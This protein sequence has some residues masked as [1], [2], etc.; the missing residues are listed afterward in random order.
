MYEEATYVAVPDDGDDNACV[1]AV[2]GEGDDQ[3][4]LEMKSITKGMWAQMLDARTCGKQN[5]KSVVPENIDTTTGTT[6]CAK[7]KCIKKDPYI[8]VF[9]GKQQILQLKIADAGDEVAAASI[10]KTLMDGYAKGEVAKVE[11]R[12]QKATLLE[13]LHAA[14]KKLEKAK[15]TSSSAEGAEA[16]AAPES[17][18]SEE[19]E[20]EEKKPKVVKKELSKKGGNGVEDDERGDTT[21]KEVVGLSSVQAATVDVAPNAV[22]TPVAAAAPSRQT[23]TASLPAAPAPRTPKKRAAE[24]EIDLTSSEEDM[25]PFEWAASGKLIRHVR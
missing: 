5:K 7:E 24:W 25:D 15:D 12:A 9:E 16:T 20:S 22:V 13:K 3:E 14:K 2:F 18:E 21:V 23:D 10:V 8:L 11:L 19:K 17:K 4:F 1:A 6:L